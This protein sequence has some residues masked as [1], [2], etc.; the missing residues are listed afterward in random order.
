MQRGRSF[1]EYTNFKF[2]ITGSSSNLTSVSGPIL[3]LYL[4]F[5]IFTGHVRGETVFTVTVVTLFYLR[6]HRSRT[7]S[8]PLFLVRSIIFENVIYYFKARAQNCE[9][10]LLTWLCLSVRPRGII[11]LSLGGF[12]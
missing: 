10:R 6:Q 3:F 1:D 7:L 12:S 8:M 2:S 9:K 4:V 5:D 11:R